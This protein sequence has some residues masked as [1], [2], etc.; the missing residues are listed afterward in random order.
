MDSNCRGKTCS[1]FERLK[2]SERSLRTQ[3]HITSQSY[4]LRMALAAC[5][6]KPTSQKKR[7]SCLA[8][9][10]HLLRIW[11]VLKLTKSTTDHF[12]LQILQKENGCNILYTIKISMAPSYS[13]LSILILL[14]LCS[15]T[16]DKQIASGTVMLN[17]NLSMMSFVS[18]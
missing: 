6:Y 18:V 17:Q 9:T 1:F 3:T 8:Q 14:F 13:W 7:Y 4:F 5:G 16:F 15:V 12:V 11:A 10:V 2:F